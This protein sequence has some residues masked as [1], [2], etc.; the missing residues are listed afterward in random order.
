MK[1][2]NSFKVPSLRNILLT[3]PYFHDGS[4]ATIEDAVKKMG[5]HQLKQRII[6]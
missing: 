3:G 1:Q 5:Y 4:I 2:R 6:R